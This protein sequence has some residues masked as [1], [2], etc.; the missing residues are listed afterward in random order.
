[1]ALF[2]LDRPRDVL[3]RRIDERAR[4]LFTAGGLVDEVRGLLEAGYRPDLRPMSG[5]GYAEAA[6]VAAGEWDVE[7]AI[8]V[9]AR[10]TRQYAKRQLSWFGRDP[11]VAWL[12]AADGPADADPI[13]NQVV[14]RVDQLVEGRPME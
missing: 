3:Y 13:V 4:W 12:P 10:R 5:H 11:R 8:E 7:H 6:H 14:V 1:V 9:T 2:A